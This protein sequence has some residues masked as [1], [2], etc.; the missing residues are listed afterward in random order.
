MDMNI[1][2]SAIGDMHLYIYIPYCRETDDH[3]YDLDMNYVVIYIHACMSYMYV[4]NLISIY[5]LTKDNF[6]L[7]IIHIH[8]TS[9]TLNI[10]MQHI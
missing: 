7:I 10:Y 3:F 9:N 5:I 2:F 6:L 4:I 8:T 1:C